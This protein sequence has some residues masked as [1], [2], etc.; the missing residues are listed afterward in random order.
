MLLCKVAR[1]PVLQTSEKEPVQVAKAWA[2]SCR[3]RLCVGQDQ[4]P[5]S[6]GHREEVQSP[7]SP[8][9]DLEL[10]LGDKAT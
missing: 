1:A 10:I 3:V 5:V 8:T 2:V 7:I 6:S 9:L 4:S